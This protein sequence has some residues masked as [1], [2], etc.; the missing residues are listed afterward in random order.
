MK[1]FLC[2]IVKSSEQFA[3]VL[4]H[5]VNC[6][7]LISIREEMMDSDK[8][9]RQILRGSEK[10]GKTYEFDDGHDPK[11]P[12][13]W[14]F[15]ES[16]EGKILFIVF[17]SMACRY[18]KCLGCNLPSKMSKK[19]IPFDDIMDQIDY[20]FALPE[21]IEKKDIIDK[22]IVSNNGSVL[23]EDTFSSTALI[24][25]IAVLNRN[26]KNL[27]KL[28]VETRPEYTDLEELEFISRALKEGQAFTQLE[29]CIGFEAFDD[30]IRNNVFFKGLAKEVF[31]DFVAKLSKYQFELKCYFM[32]KPV[33]GMSDAEGVA[34][35]AA[36]ID[37]LS[38]I[39]AKYNVSINMHLNPTYV[40]TGTALV[41]SFEKG[42]YAPP[43]LQDLASAALH[44]KNKDITVFL[45]LSD[46]GLAVDGGSFLN[47]DN[48]WMVEVL[49]EFNR[50]R[51]F[52]LLQKVING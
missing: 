52:D 8:I 34:D 12:A 50:T 49:E 4:T 11:K 19:H 37:Y 45:G 15:Q 23:D 33:P 22:V 38:E 32:L 44:S 21:V 6:A 41:D 5:N 40:A 25:L 29:I 14:W 3:A 35:I 9:T 48:E 51:N 18:S 31:E 27:K 24:Y 43:R 17:Y 39:A 7:P 13:Q 2:Y 42:E 30:N 36:G 10:G 1:I 20:I 26:F 28:A 47:S 46:E 16:D